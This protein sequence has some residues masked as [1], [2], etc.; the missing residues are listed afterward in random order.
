M[1]DFP[2]TGVLSSVEPG[3]EHEAMLF[4][5]EDLARS[6]QQLQRAHEEWVAAL[7]SL[8]DAVFIHDRDFR[9]LRCNRAYAELGG[10]PIKEVIGKVYWAVFPKGDGPLNRCRDLVNCKG[11]CESGSE[12]IL[13]NDGRVFVSHAFPV[14]DEAGEYRY[15][16]HVIED[17]TER[18]AIELALRDSEERFR[19]TFEQAAV[20]MA[21]V[22]LDG[23]WLRVNQRLCEMVGYS[24]EELSKLTFQ[25]ITHPD[26]LETD[27][28][29][30]RQ[31][32]AGEI[33]TYSMEKRYFRKDGHILWINLTVSL[34]HKADGAP[35][36]FI[37]VIEDIGARKKIEQ[38]L[39]QSSRALRT[40]SAG[41]Q[42]LIHAENEAELLESMCHAAVDV[43]GYAAAWVGFA[44]NDAGCTIEPMAQAG[45]DSELLKA[46]TL[47]WAGNDQNQGIRPAGLAIRS[48][49]TQI[50]QSIA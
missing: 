13:S 38:Q 17:I 25:D 12:E 8:E 2:L 10:M 16:L 4:M 7:D 6:R 15:S 3:K 43:G 40:L 21:H 26:D 24:I 14:L 32:L 44:R 22:A 20:G 23:T 19:L 35:D 49:K 37:A 30:V 9:I 11:H 50:A 42:S 36:Y 5:L 33:R 47:T 41:N 1:T 28:A 27:L 39:Q 18:R 34:V 45:V 29:Y 31:V 46:Q 48:G